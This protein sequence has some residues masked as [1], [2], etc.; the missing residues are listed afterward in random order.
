MRITLRLRK[1]TGLMP[2]SFPNESRAY[3]ATRP[4]L[5]LTP[6]AMTRCG[7]E[8]EHSKVMGEQVVRTSVITS[9]YFCSRCV[10]SPAIQQDTQ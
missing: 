8:P 1:G 4:T 6:V 5:T 2:L 3:D 10:R 9:I 7:S